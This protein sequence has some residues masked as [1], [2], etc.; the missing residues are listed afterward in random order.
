MRSGPAERERPAVDD[1]RPADGHN[2]FIL[3]HFLFGVG[4]SHVQ[5]KPAAAQLVSHNIASLHML[6]H[7]Q[8]YLP[9][10]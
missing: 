2:L 6:T 4:M 3:S 9:E 8:E 7:T 5:W 1:M 10:K